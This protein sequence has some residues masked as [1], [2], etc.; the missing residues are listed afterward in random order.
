[1]FKD[2]IYATG[3]FTE[4][5]DDEFS[6]IDETYLSYEEKR[7]V[8]EKYNKIYQKLN[9]KWNL[10]ED[11]EVFKLKK[12]VDEVDSLY[13]EIFPRHIVSEEKTGSSK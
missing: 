8:L 7:M 11:D 6:L 5:L 1:M 13:D 10:V 12:A 2:C 4:Y 3:C 9:S